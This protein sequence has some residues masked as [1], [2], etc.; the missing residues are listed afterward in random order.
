M[1]LSQ[2]LYKRLL[3][4]VT[5]PIGRGA[6][7]L[8]EQGP[9]PHAWHLH[10]FSFRGLYS[11]SGR[12][13]WERAEPVIAATQMNAWNTETETE[14]D[15]FYFRLPRMI[16]CVKRWG[17]FAIKSCAGDRILAGSLSW[18]SCWTSLQ[19]LKANELLSSFTCGHPTCHFPLPAL[20]F[21]LLK[22][23]YSDAFPWALSSLSIKSNCHIPPE[24]PES[25]TLS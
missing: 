9:M 11:Y 22:S 18:N 17:L 16:R 20:L 6:E 5:V 14:T 3:S 25:E 23:K 24:N 12:S 2:G 7:A 19:F 4:L 15:R 10:S 21:N 8:A 13:S 1:P